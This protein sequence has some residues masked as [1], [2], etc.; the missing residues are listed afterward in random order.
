MYSRA[1]WREE[2]RE[3][4]GTVPSNW[5]R[6]RMLFWP[7]GPNAIKA[8]ESRQEP[9]DNWRQFPLVKLK[10]SAD[11]PKTCDSYDDTTTA[12]AS[13]EETEEK[14]SRKRKTFGEDFETDVFPENEEQNV[15]KVSGGSPQDPFSLPSEPKKY[16]LTVSPGS[17]SH[18][19]ST[20]GTGSPGSISSCESPRSVTPPNSPASTS[21]VGSL[22]SISSPSSPASTSTPITL[23]GGLSSK[24]GDKL[25]ISGSS[26]PS[27][28]N[29][30]NSKL[31]SSKP[32]SRKQTSLKSVSGK[33]SSPKSKSSKMSLASKSYNAKLSS[34][35]GSGKLT[36]LRK[37]RSCNFS[38]SSR[39]AS[40]K[41]VSSKSAHDKSSP[42]P[43]S[44][45][46][47]SESCSASFPM[48]DARFQK[49]VLHQLVEV[50]ELLSKLLRQSEGCMLGDEEKIAQDPVKTKEEFLDLEK[51]LLD[52]TYRS[53]LV[54]YCRRVGG[55]DMKDMV[56]NVLNRMM[57]PSLQSEFNMK[58]LNKSKMAFGKTAL[59][60]VIEES[61]VA[62][63]NTT[64]SEVRQRIAKYLKY[65]YQRLCK[66][67]A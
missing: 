13:E 58:G 10:L 9:R 34:P 48:S 57:T 41:S 14:R 18:P 12:E 45:S 46:L 60:A 6:N 51:K 35:C 33:P 16:R 1:V 21:S 64:V 67:S 66:S 4:E 20:L 22:M 56:R 3:E 59:C 55:S 44:G 15:V 19:N 27:S 62:S 36:S 39:P 38:V 54:A 25:S 61:V 50:K 31:S 49:R 32:I 43:G 40:G 47:S 2:K 8:Y 28:P 52:V 29:S 24:H 63:H 53:A 7:P 37:S 17:T 65:S 5:I 11:D 42:K 26:K 30:G 23:F